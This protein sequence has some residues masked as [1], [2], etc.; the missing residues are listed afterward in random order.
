MI[1]GSSMHL[2][3]HMFILFDKEKITN[4]EN[5]FKFI[6]EKPFELLQRY[7]RSGLR[8]V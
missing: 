1:K 8:S 6:N 2:G 5:V 4:K 3:E 7:L